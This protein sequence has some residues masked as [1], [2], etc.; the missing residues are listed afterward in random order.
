MDFR[1]TP[2]K[3]LSTAIFAIPMILVVLIFLIFP[4]AACQSYKMQPKPIKWVFADLRITSTDFS[5]NPS[6]DIVAAYT[7]ESSSDIQIRL[8]LLDISPNIKSDIYIALDTQPGGTN[9]LPLDIKSKLYW[10]T[11]ITIPADGKPGAHIPIMQGTQF[12]RIKL[13]TDVV[14]RVTYDPWNDYVTISLNKFVFPE[15]NHLFHAQVFLTDDGSTQPMDVIGPFQFD[16]KV[17]LRAPVLIAF[18]NV[19]PAYTPAQAMRRWDGAHTGPYGERHG[20]NLLLQAVRSNE[21]P[22][23]LLDL[24]TPPAIS[25]LDYIGQLPTIQ[26]LVEDKL[27]ILPDPLPELS[28][29][30]EPNPPQEMDFTG[31]ESLNFQ[32]LN[33]E[34]M[35]E[36]AR[37]EARQVSQQFNLPLSKL[38]YAPQLPPIPPDGYHIVFSLSSEAASPHRW[39]ESTLI[40]IPQETHELQATTEGL[41]LFKRKELL[42]L[43]QNGNYDISNF[44]ILG[45]NLP[46][47]TWGDPEAANATLRYIAEHPWIKPLTLDDLMAMRFNSGETSL[48]N[49]IPINNTPSPIYHQDMLTLFCM[50]AENLLKNP[51]STAAMQ[52]YLSLFSPLPPESALLHKLRENYF[53]QIENLLMAAQWAEQPYTLADCS[54]DTNRD[55]QTECILASKKYFALFD[56]SGARLKYLFIRLSDEKDVS[57]KVHQLIGPTSQFLVGLGDPSTWNLEAGEASESEGVHGAF[58]D[59]SYRWDIYSLTEVSPGHITF[60][61]PDGILTKSFKFDENRLSVEYKNTPPITVRIPLA[62]DPWTR[63]T[64]D[65]GIRYWGNQTT[66][67]SVWGLHDGPQ[68]NI[69]S[70]GIVELHPFTASQDNLIV[71]ENPNFEYPPGHFLPFP[72]ALIEIQSTSETLTIQLDYR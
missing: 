68:I 67:G 32:S 66:N 3:R 58:S 25:A 45:G 17:K 5:E 4:L 51:V 39:F 52:S 61:S 23:A 50:D 56:R 71:R 55:G 29:N 16:A 2:I 54:L 41:S 69:T 42:K 72:I 13:R 7:R 30:D 38:L 14:P 1:I 24:R 40:P 57:S 65:W 37:M 27:L 19:F 12:P 49:S 15:Q 60:T 64:P 26:K 35:L 33:S 11:L 62:L 63:F 20:L 53:H 18:W 31:V 8:D 6:Q 70:N 47:T 59:T 10:D 46:E 22:I 9:D 34:W 44:I 36:C 28:V 48:S 43:V 21:I